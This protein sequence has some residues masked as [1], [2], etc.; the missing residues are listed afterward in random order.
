MQKMLVAAALAA[1]AFPSVAF[2]DQQP[3]SDGEAKLA[4]LLNGMVKK[5][6]V[7]CMAVP[8]SAGVVEGTALVFRRG[9]TL[10]VNRPRSGG[11]RLNDKVLVVRSV[12]SA[13][14]CDGQPLDLLDRISGLPAGH[15]LLG[16]F[17][18]Y[19]MP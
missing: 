16:D 3:A 15:V 17:V 14:L 4:F 12:S 5:E 7:G 8:A 18:P 9:N 19:R 11:E 13:N 10:Y 1:V 6:P 2:A